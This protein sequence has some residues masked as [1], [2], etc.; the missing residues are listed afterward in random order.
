MPN[1]ID[2]SL[3]ALNTRSL[4]ALLL[5]GVLPL[6]V[7]LGITL[8][9]S[10][11]RPLRAVAL[12]TCIAAGLVAGLGTWQLVSVRMRID[13]TSIVLGGGFY[14]VSVPLDR[15]GAGEEIERVRN[16]TL[17]IRT[18]GIS[19]PGLSL[20]WFHVPGRGRTFAAIT[21]PE[22]VVSIPTQDGYTVLV[23]PDDPDS[24]V[25]RLRRRER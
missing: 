12:I 16:Y 4:L 25:D 14:R 17:G 7:V 21:D 13:A 22:K 2:V 8:W 23:S 1:P 24:V 5:V 11:G 15:L 19:M 6:L 9:M 18:N 3:H 20:G 10:E